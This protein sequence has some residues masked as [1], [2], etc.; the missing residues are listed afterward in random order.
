M[1][2]DEALVRA[3]CDELQQQR[4]LVDAPAQPRKSYLFL[5]T[6]LLPFTRAAPHG[7]PL[8][9]ENG[10]GSS[11]GV[12]RPLSTASDGPEG[13]PPMRRGSS[14]ALLD[15]GVARAGSLARCISAQMPQMQETT[16]YVSTRSCARVLPS[17]S[18]CCGAA[19]ACVVRCAL[20]A[21]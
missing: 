9:S 4:I 6:S 11:D 2:V 10:V 5:C 21:R 17:C 8:G 14:S 18:R 20:A 19:P 3:R 1:H 15:E 13:A 16:A 12:G 7:V